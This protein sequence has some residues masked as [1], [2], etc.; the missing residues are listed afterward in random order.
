M[1]HGRGFLQ[2]LTVLLIVKKFP[3]LCGTWK[4]ITVFKTACHLVLSFTKLIPS[5]APHPMY[6]R[7]TSLLPSILHQSSK[8]TLSFR[9]TPQNHLYSALLLQTCYMPHPF[10]FSFLFWSPKQYTYGNVNNHEASIRILE[11]GK[12][13]YP[14]QESSPGTPSL[15]PGS[16]VPIQLY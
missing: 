3:I 10:S 15:Q 4:F 12:I 11:K 16:L 6:L 14:S 1:P 9:F 13:F 8:A 7:L 5:K 2:T